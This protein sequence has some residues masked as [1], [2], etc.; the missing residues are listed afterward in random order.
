MRR[1]Y[2]WD[3]EQ[4]KL[5]EVSTQRQLSDL[6]YVQGD[7]RRFQSPLDGSF[8]DGKRELREH[9]RRYNVVHADPMR[10]EERARRVAERARAEKRE[11]LS[12]ICDSFEHIRNQ[13]RALGK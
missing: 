3:K 2:V 8:V 13:N 11:R 9:M 10:P 4:K 6:H 1:R 5:V 12:A 7:A